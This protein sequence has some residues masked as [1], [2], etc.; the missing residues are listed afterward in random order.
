MLSIGTITGSLSRLLIWLAALSAAGDCQCAIAGF[1]ADA[2]NGLSVLQ[3]GDDASPGHSSDC[4][5][6]RQSQSPYSA[7]DARRSRL[8]RNRRGCLDELFDLL[9]GSITWLSSAMT[10]LAQLVPGLAICVVGL[11]VVTPLAAQDRSW[12][13]GGPP[14]SQSG[15]F[16]DDALIIASVPP[17]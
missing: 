12:L 8:N 10:M 5:L 7:T 9:S 11:C 2:A 13:D 6:R 14:P 17:R 3:P 15:R 4:A 16:P 1:D